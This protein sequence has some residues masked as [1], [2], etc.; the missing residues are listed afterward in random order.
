MD[1]NIELRRVY[2]VRGGAPNNWGLRYEVNDPPT[3]GW[4]HALVI[5]GER[6]STIFCP[7]T[8]F[9][10]QVSNKSGEM[11]SGDVKPL[12]AKRMGKLVT[13]TWE[14]C[15]KF[16]W[17]RDFGVAA[18]VLGGLG[19]PVPKFLPP[20][21]DELRD[22]EEHKGRGGKQVAEDALRPCNPESKRGAVA[23]FFLQSGEP[24]SLHEAMAKLGMTRSGVLSHLF[25][26]NKDH[27]VGYELIRDCARIIVPEGFD[28]FAWTAPVKVEKPAP[29]NADGTPK[30]P[31]KK[32]TSGKALVEEKLSPIPQPGKRATVA[33]I[34]LDWAPIAKAQEALD[35][36]RSAVL[37]HLFTINKENGLGYELSEDST[38]ARLLIPEGHEVFCAKQ[39][40]KKTK[41]SEA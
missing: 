32:R 12:D 20:P 5:R 31:P 8:L 3:S 11:R 15:V 7:F 26:L 4:S 29:V 25:T 18:M 36:D 14:M 35:I 30:D 10:Y 1:S 23:K 38:K 28:L 2:F 39:S 41:T 34:F 21:V 13:D 40:R 16:G 19:Q 6:R 27:G 17:Q 24:Q 37:S 9:A 33:G 22:G